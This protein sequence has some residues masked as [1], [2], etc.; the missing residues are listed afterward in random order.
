MEDWWNNTGGGKTELLEENVAAWPLCPPQ[1][2]RGMA[3]DW[4]WVSMVS[5]WCFCESRCSPE[6]AE[7]IS[8]DGGDDSA[9]LLFHLYV[10]TVSAMH[11]LLALVVTPSSTV[12]RR[13]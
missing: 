5:D 9:C 8:V 3:W 2:Q 12:N 10:V 7:R 13:T 1:I 4:T 11:M 6:A